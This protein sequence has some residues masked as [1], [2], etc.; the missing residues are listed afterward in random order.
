[1]VCRFAS[2]V[3]K[4]LSS[5]SVLNIAML[6]ATILEMSK[7]LTLN[8]GVHRSSTFV[9]PCTQ[10][11]VVNAGL[12]ERCRRDAHVR[13]ETKQVHTNPASRP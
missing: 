2:G 1:M 4:Q 8:R 5:P 3:E 12:K 13:E 7:K 11:R 9:R 6:F 10:I